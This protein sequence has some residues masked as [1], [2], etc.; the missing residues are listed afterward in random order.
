[1]TSRGRVALAAIGV[2]AIAMTVRMVE[3]HPFTTTH[4]T[5]TLG[6]LGIVL[7][8]CGLLAAALVV[9][10]RPASRPSWWFAAAG[11]LSLV[12]EWAGWADGPNWLRQLAAT[13]PAWALASLGMGVL[14]L[15]RGGSRLPGA[16]ALAV[17]AVS[18]AMAR[19]LLTDPFLDPRCWQVCTA[20]PLAVADHGSAAAALRVVG[21]VALTVGTGMS[22]GRWWRSERTRWSGLV[23][24][25]ALV[26]GLVIVAAAVGRTATPTMTAFRHAGVAASILAPGLAL[27]L[28]AERARHERRRTALYA[29]VE[30]M[31]RTR[32]AGS[33]QRALRDALGDAGLQV[34]Y[35]SPTRQEWVDE[36]GGPV[37]DPR[38]E[39]AV[40][41]VERVGQPIARLAHRA[42]FDQDEI[43]RVIRPAVR[44]SIENEQLRAAQ[45][46][47]LAALRASRG[48]IVEQG[49][50]E[51]R[52]LERNLHDGAQQRI[53]GI[54]LLLRAL[55]NQSN[56]DLRSLD[57]C[58]EL[59]A[60]T[61]D[62]LRRLADG[63]HP[64]VLTAGGLGAALPDLA[65]SSAD[66]AVVIGD[67]PP[68]RLPAAV[69]S[70]AY[71]VVRDALTDARQ[72]QAS[73]LQVA[74]GV[75]DGVVAVRCVDDGPAGAGRHTVVELEDRVGA[76]DGQITVTATDQQTLVEVELP[77][78]S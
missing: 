25:A 20:N 46:A 78:G 34:S 51:R 67:L 57:R 75:E 4:G 6:T 2:A 58:D 68:G 18:T 23:A 74:V 11:L 33:L 59:A 53:V 61:L 63:I 35:W 14:T 76:L 43:E 60:A 62:E 77:C 9:E 54:G 30:D 65:E 73:T 3:H 32:A 1:M 5:A 13:G 44:L 7:P 38:V 48:R 27:A 47:E 16:V 31:V 69:E 8:A 55:R 12:P 66:V 40:T 70:A 15:V 19:V 10:D 64:A 26:P 56:L 21:A 24:C 28:G 22:F 42:G 36:A 41:V 17:G 72:R 49:D 52:R 39:Q 71:L 50:A 45:L 29:V 37:G